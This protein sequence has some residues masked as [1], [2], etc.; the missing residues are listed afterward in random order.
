MASAIRVRIYFFMV[1][2]LRYIT[3]LS[4]IALSQ[5]RLDFLDH[6]GVFA[7]AEHCLAGV[8]GKDAAPL[9]PVAILG[10]QMD[11]QVAAGVSVSAVIKLL[12]MESCVNRLCSA[13]Y[14]FHE[15]RTFLCTYIDDLADVIFVSNN[16]APWMALLAEKNQLAHGELTDRDAKASSSSPPMQ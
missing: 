14:V 7:V 9:I 11:V 4:Y 12:R 13:G 2:L 3:F 5:I 15:S 10:Y 16:A 6:L 8:H 1:C